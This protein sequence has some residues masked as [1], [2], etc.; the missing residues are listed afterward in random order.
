[1]QAGGRLV[2]ACLPGQALLR[3]LDLK[4]A[5][6]R[7]TTTLEG[8]R[9]RAQGSRVAAD[10]RFAE[11][12]ADS[13]GAVLARLP[14]GKGE[15]ILLGDPWTLSNEGLDQGTNARMGLSLVGQAPHF[16]QAPG[17]LGVEARLLASPAVRAMLGLLGVLGL[18]Y[19]VNANVRFSR[20]LELPVVRYR[21]QMEYVDSAAALYQRLGAAQLP[22]QALRQ[23]A[24]I[25]LARALGL[26]RAAPWPELLERLGPHAGAG[27][28]EAAL[29]AEPMGFAEIVRLQLALRK[30]EGLL[31]PATEEEAHGGDR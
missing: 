10:Q 8:L 6:G 18:L 23:W 12:V 16:L 17:Q 29:H 2:L 13:G 14:L 11:Q 3:R 24:Q 26:R 15:V 5:P 21:S 9:V 22:G 19:V 4:L 31:R 28:L 25:R 30:V 7:D 1:V 20:P 27:E